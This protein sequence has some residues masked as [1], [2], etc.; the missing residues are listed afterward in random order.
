MTCAHLAHTLRTPCA[1]LARTS[2]TPSMCCAHLARTAHTLRAPR[3]HFSRGPLS[4]A[5]RLWLSV[6]YKLPDWRFDLVLVL[7]HRP[8]IWLQ[9]DDVALLSFSVK[10]GND[11]EPFFSRLALVHSKI[12]QN[13]A[14]IAATFDKLCDRSE[15]CTPRH[16][17]TVCVPHWECAWR[18][19]IIPWLLHPLDL[20]HMGG[21][22][23]RVETLQVPEM[24]PSCRAK[25]V[26]TILDSKMLSRVRKWID[27][28]VAEIE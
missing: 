24:Y 4:T 17:S 3:A 7:L 26:K 23:H 13:R 6:R 8:L 27:A 11:S 1:H 20:M 5:R 25:M 21:L 28:L 15:S 16:H 14:I 2:R 12:A 18:R 19:G 10:I 9:P 22:Y